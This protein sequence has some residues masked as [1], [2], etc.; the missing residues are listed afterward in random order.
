[1][2]DNQCL[3]TGLLDIA[4]HLPVV[5]TVHHPITR[6]RVLDLDAATWWRKP[7]VHRWYGFTN[8]QKK[9]ARRIPDLL[10]VSS[11]SAADIADDF[12]VRPDQLH[13]VPLGVDTEQFKPADA[14][15]V[16]GRIIAISSSEVITIERSPPPR[17]AIAPAAMPATMPARSSP[18][19]EMGPA[20][21]W[22]ANPRP[23]QIA[24][25]SGRKQ[26]QLSALMHGIA[27]TIPP[28][29]PTSRASFAMSPSP[30]TASVGTGEDVRADEG[31]AEVRVQGAPPGAASSCPRKASR[32]P[33]RGQKASSGPVGARQEGQEAE[34]PSSVVIVSP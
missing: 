13:V 25:A 1:V 11:S 18:L 17:A 23:T 4:A 27:P 22:S 31:S 15:R 29:S 28:T 9:V 30:R 34:V 5:A 21:R 14:P 10:T 19:K 3:G 20:R 12:G 16:P 24:A 6:D 7:S 26:Q 2:H 32:C 33:Q 8:M